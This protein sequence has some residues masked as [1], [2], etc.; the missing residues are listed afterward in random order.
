MTT[1]AWL[2]SPLAKV[3]IAVTAA[4]VVGIVALLTYDSTAAAVAGGSVLW[5][6]LR[7]L[8]GGKAADSRSDARD[9]RTA[10]ADVAREASEV[11]AVRT[12]ERT[13]RDAERVAEAAAEVPRME[14]PAD[15]R[16]RAARL[17]ALGDDPWGE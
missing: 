3:L 16:E 12:R 4:A 1:P 14:T 11:E 2:Q 15:E 7:W 5:G 17:A 10:A 8:F 13:E 9:R 6:G